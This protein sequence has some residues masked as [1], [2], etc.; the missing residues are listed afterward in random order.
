M[1]L[2]F[3]VRCGGKKGFSFEEL[4]SQF[5]LMDRNGD[6]FITPHELRL[7]NNS[8]TEDQVTI[9]FDIYDEDDD[10]VVTFEEYLVLLDI[11]QQDS[12]NKNYRN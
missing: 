6:G 3:V 4:K 11:N 2:A 12:S 7:S 1:L 5:S 8:I 9:F 10:A